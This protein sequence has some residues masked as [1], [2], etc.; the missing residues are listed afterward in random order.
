[1]K[2]FPVSGLRFNEYFYPMNKFSIS[3]F[4]LFLVLS[5]SLQAGGKK[6]LKT[7]PETE[8]N[9]ALKNLEE[10]VE[11]TPEETVK[12][13]DS[14]I[15]ESIDYGYDES[16]AYAYVLMGR[17]YKE[18]GLPQL[19]LHFLKLADKQNPS[20]RPK[21]STQA[22]PYKPIIKPEDYLQDYAEIHAQLGSYA[23]SNK[24]Y[25]R[26]RKN[27]KDPQK[28]KEAGY[29]IARNFYALEKFEEAA[30]MYEELVEKEKM[31]GN[32][33]GVRLCYSRLAAC[34]ISMGNTQRGLDYYELFMKGLESGSGQGKIQ[35]GNEL[36][37]QAL[38]KQ[39][40]YEEEVSI[41]NRALEITNDKIEYLRLAQTY[42]KAGNIEK[43]E[44][45]LDKYFDDISYSLIDFEEIAVIKKMA[46]ELKKRDKDEKAFRYLMTY[47][48]LSDTIRNRLLSLE[49]RAR[50]LGSS[51][52]QNV[53]ELE[54]LRKD[55]EIS[56]NAIDHLM[57]Q[58]KLKEDLVG[59]QKAII[60]LLSAVIILGIIA[61]LYIIRVSKQRRKANQQLALR[62]L[63]SQMNPHFI[64][65]ALNSVNS[66][67]SVS[68]ERAANRFLTEF[69]TLMRTVMENSEHDFIPLYKELEIIRIYVELEHFRFKDKF[70][71]RI[72][73]DP[74]LDEEEFKIP[75]MLIQPYIENAIWHGLRYKEE[76]GELLISFED[77]GDKL[78]VKIQDDGIGRRKSREI[79][80]RNQKK[81]KS[82]ALKNIGQRVRL[83]NSLH[84]IKVDVSVKDLNDN[85][86]GTVAILKIPKLD[87][88]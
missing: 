36:V 22:A 88:A 38:R 47:E 40:K 9:K 34:Y 74:R 31:A 49:Q 73:V 53:L 29:A 52:Y 17:A 11:E 78:I 48:N 26:Y 61:L 55:K 67:I 18:L 62:S 65:N 82:T 77:K 24:Y 71:Y 1:M 60:I 50:E 16:T 4:I 54:V 68:D 86:S 69:S 27:L 85:G 66:F 57:S 45:S 43:A 8:I 87:V 42:Y 64:F 14:L 76:K 37:T 51:G 13:L 44:N 35:R 30:S 21:T 75:A 15:K 12:T 39:K 23:E 59:F 83:F 6:V 32:E 56:E 3:F 70:S 81:N 28:R 41:R 58:S 33:S 20:P 25:Q 79:K 84:K 19:A 72:E 2:G 80:T 10:K 5:G 46:S 7:G 63:R